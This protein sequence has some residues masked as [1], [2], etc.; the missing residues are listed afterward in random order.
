MLRVARNV[1]GVAFRLGIS[2]V[3]MKSQNLH[4]STVIHFA[5]KQPQQVTSRASLSNKRQ[6]TRCGGASKVQG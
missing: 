1:P 4:E 3:C 2:N 6:T 5:R